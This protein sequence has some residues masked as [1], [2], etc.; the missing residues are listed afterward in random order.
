MDSFRESLRLQLIRELPEFVEIDTRPE[1]ERMGNRLRRGIVSGCAGLTDAG[2]NCSIH[3]FL[4]GNAKLPST[5]FQQSREIIV[6]RQG[7][8]HFRI[9]CASVLMSTHQYFWVSRMENGRAAD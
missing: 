5:L 4:K 6:E 2:T 3:R 1:P 9:I 8:P 7:R